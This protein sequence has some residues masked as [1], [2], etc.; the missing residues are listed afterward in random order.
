[1]KKELPPFEYPIDPNHYCICGVDEAGRGPLMGNVV[2]ACV[3]LDR[4]NPIEGLNDSKKLSEKKRD[5][6]E[7]V[8]KEKALA[9]GIG[10]CTP[11]EID[12]LNILNA[13]LE[14]M[15]RAYLNMNRNCHLM[16][17]DGNKTPKDLPI[18]MEAV[19]K[20]D[21]RVAEIAAASILAKVERDRQMYELD[22]KYPEYEFA[23]HKGYPTA[24]HLELLKTLPILDFYRKSYS[25]I[26]KILMSSSD[27]TVL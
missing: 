21:A 8:I 2:A 16:L 20:G 12:S 14:A 9:Y 24:R 26:K 7:P 18:K 10:I 23:K 3:I 1:M 17:V 13:S 27:H 25:P 5:L 11:Q 15:K 22:R 4:N 19:V 6:L